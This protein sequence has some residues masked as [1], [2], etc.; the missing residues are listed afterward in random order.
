MSTKFG[1][2]NAAVFALCAL[3]RLRLRVFS[4][5]EQIPDKMRPAAPL[6]LCG[7]RRILPDAIKRGCAAPP[8][9]A[10]LCNGGCPLPSDAA[11]LTAARNGW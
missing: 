10:L 3:C 8:P 7:F 11:A 2:E 4:L 6:I 5:S 9:G 1:T